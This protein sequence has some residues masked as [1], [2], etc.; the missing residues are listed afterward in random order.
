MMVQLSKN[1]KM[2]WKR[3]FIGSVLCGLGGWTTAQAS[4]TQESSPAYELNV[5]AKQA[6]QQL[7]QAF[8]KLNQGALPQAIVQLEKLVQAYPN[9]HLARLIL[10]EFRLIQAGSFT[11]LKRLRQK[12]S[13]QQLLAGAKTRWQYFQTPSLSEHLLEE[14]IWKVGQTPFVVL[15]NLKENRLYLYQ[16]QA[17]N[18]L[19]LVESL[20][21][22]FGKKG[23]GKRREGDKRTPIGVYKIDNWIPDDELPELYGVGALTLDYPNEWDRFKG[24]TGSGIWL[25]GTP[26]DIFARA[27]LDSRG[28]VV[29][30]NHAMLRLAKQYGLQKHTPVLLVADDRHHSMEAGQ[31]KDALILSV[32]H[33]LQKKVGKDALQKV[34]SEVTIFRYPAEE[35]MAYVQLPAAM[36]HQRYFWQKQGEAWQLADLVP[37]S[38]QLTMRK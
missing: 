25:H 35:G 16:K 2:Q 19:K 20:Y 17:E 18:K 23:F 21:I 6:E 11:A 7:I 29:L 36:K 33:W 26:R 34:W 38:R 4:F 1:K 3:F 10:A 12:S 5:Q 37:P 31:D 24:R 14:Y 8:S 27:P 9:Y 15:V 30:N 22:T 28:C 32:K 13:V